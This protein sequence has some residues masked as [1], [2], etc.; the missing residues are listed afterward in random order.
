MRVKNRKSPKS[1]DNVTSKM[2]SFAEKQ[3]E[4]QN[5]YQD[6][7]IM[8]KDTTDEILYRRVENLEHSKNQVTSIDGNDLAETSSKDIGSF[9]K[10]VRY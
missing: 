2:L 7:F 8:K 1:G 4:L 6:E 9:I 5:G 10:E 3:T